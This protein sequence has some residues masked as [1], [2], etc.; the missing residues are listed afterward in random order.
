MIECTTLDDYLAKYGK[1]LAAQAERSLKPLHRPGIDACDVAVLE[2]EPFEAQAHVCCA[3]AKA[4]RRQKALKVIGEMGVGK[5]L[6]AQGI[7]Q[8]HANGRPYRALVMCPGQLVNKWEREIKETI[9]NPVIIKIENWRQVLALGRARRRFRKPK[10]PTWI[11]IP[12]D[13]A[14]LGYKWRAAYL[15][16]PGRAGIFCPGCD[17]LLIKENAS[18]KDESLGQAGLLLS[19]ADLKKRHRTCD[20]CG[21]QLWQATSELMR[22]EPAKLFHKKLRGYLDYFIADEAHEE[23]SAD[24][25]QGNALGALCASAKKILALTGTLIG[26]YAEHIRPLLMRMCPRT[27]IQEGFTWRSAMA[28]SEVYGRI[29]TRITE[30]SGGGDG[31]SNRQSRGKS[32]TKTRIV[33]P[34]IMPTLFGRHLMANAVFLGLDEVASNL[35]PFQEIVQGVQMDPQVRDCYAFVQAAMEEVIRQMVRRGDKRFLGAM[36]STL[37]AY[38]DHPYGWGQ[39]GYWEHLGVPEP[40]FIP[41]VEPPNL[42]P[43]LVRPKETALI[44]IVEEERRLGRQCWVYTVMTGER[45]VAGRL[46]NLLQGRGLR[47]TVL[48]ST[49]DLADREEW[50]LAHGKLNDVII[51]HPKLVETGLDLFD[52]GGSHNFP[53]LIFYSTGYNT[54]TLRQASRRAWRIG[55]REPCKVY[56]LFYEDPEI[57]TMQSR[58][59]SLMG[60]KL[61]ASR[62]IEGKFSSEGLVSMAGED[63]VEMALAKSLANNI[64]EGSPT[65]AWLKIGEIK[66]ANSG[67]DMNLDDFE[68]DMAELIKENPELFDGALFPGV[69]S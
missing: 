17:T 57:Q 43:K 7:V 53:T 56:Y 8:T 14:K 65:R 40:T 68:R 3:G 35:P 46:S 60:K 49:V 9:P 41:V 54:F 25:A 30:R 67:R 31:E 10:R 69:A 44:K 52:K 59:M 12:R 11:I 34:G 4:L 33:R 47:S 37:L 19:P 15:T 32:K 48:R 13:R 28:F 66:D 63:S 5:T 50:I 38:P 26:G 22:M 42:D 51:S 61:A 21:E 62:A 27:L 2:R 16:K 36:L 18:G 58:A 45:D 23:K 24:S 55:Q 20:H 6:I 39:V 64:D 29:E 1:V